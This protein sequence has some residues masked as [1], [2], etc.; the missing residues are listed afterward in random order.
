M[1]TDT[2]THLDK[3][4]DPEE[5]MSR[6]RSEGVRR[7]IT[8][9]TESE[10]WPE[11]LKLSEKFKSEVFGTLGMHPH[12]ASS[13]DEQCETFLKKH[14]S[15]QSVIAVGEIGLDYYYEHSPKDIQK[16][17]FYRQLCLAEEWGLPVEIHTRDAEEDTLAIL[18]EFQGRVQGLLH[19][20]TGSYQMARQALDWG[21][22][23]SFSGIVTFKNSKDLQKTCRKIPLD[24]L[25]IETDAPY[26]APVPHRGKENQPSW[27]IY[28]AQK[29]CELHNVKEDQ[30]S[31]QLE[32]NTLNMFPKIQTG[33]A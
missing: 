32:E 6:A 28:V 20:F 1:W 4:K 2:H 21:F 12:R 13:F 26:L 15:D 8:V 18:K 10:D 25:H 29:I 14:L 16:E 31:R 11:V 33:S 24:R 7:L 19:C 3:L 22:N 27:V 23:I 17:V 5:V 30:L 9:G